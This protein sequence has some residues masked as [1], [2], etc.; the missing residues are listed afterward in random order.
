MGDG[1]K[2]AQR[3]APIV[4]SVRRRVE[5]TRIADTIDLGDMA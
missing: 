1:E 3:A 2:S 4:I 5:K